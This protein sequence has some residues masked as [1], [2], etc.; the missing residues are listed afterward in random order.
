MSARLI[1]HLLKEKIPDIRR[2]WMLVV[3][4][5]DGDRE[6]QTERGTE[7]NSDTDGTIETRDIGTE[8][9]QTKRHQDRDTFVRVNAQLQRTARGW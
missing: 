9:S 1:L 3:A 5:R 8:I 6:I 4:L 7:S 2:L